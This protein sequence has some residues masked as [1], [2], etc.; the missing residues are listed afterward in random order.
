[1]SEIKSLGSL[2]AFFI[3]YVRTWFASPVKGHAK[4]ARQLKVGQTVAVR[5]G[6][7]LD[8]TKLSADEF[9]VH[10]PSL[11]FREYIDT[12]LVGKEL[13]GD[14]YCARL[15]PAFFKKLSLMKVGDTIAWVRGMTFDITKLGP[16]EF[17]DSE[18]CNCKL[19]GELLWGAEGS[20]F[21]TYLG[22][23]T[24]SALERMRVG[25]TATLLPV[26]GSERNIDCP[27]C[28]S[29]MCG[30]TASEWRIR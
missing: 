11:K 13:R 10:D 8:I 2:L 28:G 9:R 4:A 5:S 18:E 3:S 14:I 7:S 15:T 25:N 12:K 6:C 24:I 23:G 1:M 22:P 21:P 29:P 20:V 30:A 17:L 27:L 16:N 26:E 19:D